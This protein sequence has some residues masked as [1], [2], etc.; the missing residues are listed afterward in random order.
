[1][2]DH[3]KLQSQ[4]HIWNQFKAGMGTL[5]EMSNRLKN[6]SQLAKQSDMLIFNPS[7]RVQPPNLWECDVN[8]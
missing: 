5:G 8:L 3:Q 6:S 4:L 2:F 7:F 1:M